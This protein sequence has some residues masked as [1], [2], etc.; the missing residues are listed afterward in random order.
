VGGDF[1]LYEVLVNLSFTHLLFLLFVYIF[2]LS[3]S[4]KALYFMTYK[5]A[6]AMYN[7]FIL[8]P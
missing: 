7:I 8:L 1:D 5:R 3:L 6:T 4:A 2:L